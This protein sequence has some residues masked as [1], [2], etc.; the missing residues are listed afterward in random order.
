MEN[1]KRK[2]KAKKAMQD[3][4]IDAVN[5]HKDDVLKQIYETEYEGYQGY[6]IMMNSGAFILS[7]YDP[8]QYPSIENQKDYCDFPKAVKLIVFCDPRLPKDAL[9]TGL[10]VM[11]NMVEESGLIGYGF[12]EEERI[13]RVKE[14]DEI[15]RQGQIGAFPSK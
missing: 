14:R 4:M 11:A 3:G 13:K 5:Q 6:N 15:N 8:N 9:I 1:S 12:T 7:G 2:Q 10:K